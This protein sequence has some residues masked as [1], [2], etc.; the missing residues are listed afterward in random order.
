MDQERQAAHGLAQ[1]H[2]AEARAKVEHQAA[3][4]RLRGL[5]RKSVVRDAVEKAIDDQAD[6]GDVE[7][8]VTRICAA[9]AGR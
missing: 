8:M 5:I 1:A 2:A 3:Y 9:A 4:E 7:R 6:S